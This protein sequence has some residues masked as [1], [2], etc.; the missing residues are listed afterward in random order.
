MWF[1]QLVLPPPPIVYHQVL[2]E[3]GI[4]GCNTAAVLSSHQ[5]DIYLR[6]CGHV[7]HFYLLI[8]ATYQSLAKEHPWAEHL[9]SL[10]KRCVG[11]LSCLST[12]MKEPPCMLTATHC[13]RIRWSIGRTIMYNGGIVLRSW[14]SNSMQQALNGSIRHC[15]RGVASKCGCIIYIL[16]C[17]ATL[18][19]SV[20]KVSHLRCA[21][22]YS[23]KALP[24]H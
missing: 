17:K 11:A 7:L 24:G 3:P 22:Q 6:R 9:T 4:A 19:S 5:S 15:E 14:S 10:P 8:I 13:P 1:L 23:M 20:C 12:T 16:L 18:Q 21:S 2:G